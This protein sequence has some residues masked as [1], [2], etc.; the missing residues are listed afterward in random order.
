MRC[1]IG[2]PIFLTVLL[3]LLCVLKTAEFEETRNRKNRLIMFRKSAEAL[4][5]EIKTHP[6]S[7]LK[8]PRKLFEKNLDL[9]KTAEKICRKLGTEK[10][11]IRRSGAQN[12]GE[13]K[14]SA[15]DEGKIYEFIRRLFFE[16]PGA[17]RLRSVKFL[18]SGGIVS[19]IIAFEVSAVEKCPGLVLQKAPRRK[20]DLGSLNLFGIKKSGS[21]KLLC[22]ADDSGAY[23]DDS[24]FRVGDFVGGRRLTEIFPNAVEIKGEGP[25]KIR[26]GLGE[27]W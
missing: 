9:R 7:P 26:I 14:I 2:I 16:L 15:D 20:A 17:V 12:I 10:A 1:K 24:W 6:F 5:R 23:I 4:A 27:S 3:V 25:S 19:A 11:L 18:P 8:S 21:H 13:I 22:I